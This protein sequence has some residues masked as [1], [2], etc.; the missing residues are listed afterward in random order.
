MERMACGIDGY[1]RTE[2][3]ICAYPDFADI[4]NSEI[5][6]REKVL[7]DLDVVSVIAVERLFDINIFA[8]LTENGLDE[9]VLLF[10]ITGL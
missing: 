6:V 8:G 7:S 2:L 5:V 1:A 3:G 10:V 9:S 4:K